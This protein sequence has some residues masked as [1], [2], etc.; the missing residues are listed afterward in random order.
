[1]WWNK[2]CVFVL[3]RIFT[4]WWAIFKIIPLN[5]KIY[6]IHHKTSCNYVYF[7]YV[8]IEYPN[9][10]VDALLIYFN[11]LITQEDAMGS[12]CC[13]E[14][15]VREECQKTWW[16]HSP[17]IPPYLINNNILIIIINISNGDGNPKV[18]RFFF[19]CYRYS[20]ISKSKIMSADLSEFLCKSA[21]LSKLWI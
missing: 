2:C 10:S 16:S 4:G 5:A 14:S 11:Y 13:P 1:M 12:L 3:C 7:I 20:D 21:I 17:R 8:R 18:R 9:S 19:Y 6:E 15:H